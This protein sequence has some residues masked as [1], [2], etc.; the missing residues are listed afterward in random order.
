MLN[1]R[2]SP[3]TECVLQKDISWFEERYYGKNDNFYTSE[4]PMTKMGNSTK[5]LPANLTP[6]CSVKTYAQY[7]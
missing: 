4:D 5:L 7:L 2:S 3:T 1:V 6:S